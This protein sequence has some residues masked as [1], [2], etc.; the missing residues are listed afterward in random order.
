MSLPRPRDAMRAF[1]AL[2]LL[3][4]FMLAL[5]WLMEKAVP[6]QNVQLVTYMLGQ[7]SI[8]AGAAVIFYFGT[9]KSSADKN[10]LLD[11]VA[12]G[13]P[14]MATG[15][16][17]DPVHFDGDEPFESDPFPAPGFG[18]RQQTEGEK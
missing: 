2:L 4:A 9:S 7:L 5:L 10:E 16:P 11:R 12:H 6:Q 13:R 18:A 17:D 15:K 8:M 3:G 1:L 14:D